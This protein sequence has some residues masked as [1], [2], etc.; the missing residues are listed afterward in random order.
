LGLISLNSL[1]STKNKKIVRVTGPFLKLRAYP[2]D[3]F[4]VMSADEYERREHQL[5]RFRRLFN[6]L[7]NGEIKRNSFEPWEID[8]ILDFE[9]CQLP[10][11]RRQDIL[12]QYQRAVERQ[13]ASGPGPPLKLSHF[14]I[15]REQRR[16][17]L[18]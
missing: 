2:A 4:T 15:L 6:E 3:Q 9:S 8:L 7:L 11:R 13:M 5:N 16:N 14:L 12:G 18:P 1:E 17:A 10:S